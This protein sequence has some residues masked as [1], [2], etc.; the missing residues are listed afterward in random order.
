MF[1]AVLNENG[2]TY[3]QVPD[4]I[5][6]SDSVLVAVRYCGICGSD[7]PRVFQHKVRKLP[8]I[9]GHEFSGIVVKIGS[10]VHNVSVGESVVGIP[11]I[12][13]F[14]CSVCSEG[15]YSSCGNYKFV[16]SRL[17]GGYAQYVS[18]PSKN[19]I[20][21]P[22]TLPLLD[23]ALVEP[24]TVSKHAFNFVNVVDKDV[25]VVGSGIIGLFT[26]QWAKIL[27]AKKVTLITHGNKSF[28]ISDTFADIIT[29]DSLVQSNTS[30]VVFDC[31][32][33]SESF[34]TDYYVS[35][36]GA[37]VVLI[38]TPTQQVNFS[39]SDWEL[40]NRKE[41]KIIG[42]WMSYSDPFPGSEWYESIRYLDSG[43]LKISKYMIHGVY[44]LS[45]VKKVFSDIQTKKPNGRVIFD[46]NK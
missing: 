5:L 34:R 38:G 14:N 10:N 23:A 4:P 43:N 41:L 1:A 24:S 28:E 21:I 33:N 27:G 12:P 35:K 42:S 46:I 30:D 18:L 36:P 17:N 20:V 7:Y 39:I 40:I 13:C 45:E 16:G 15:K 44:G 8:I 37:S 6:D 25:V 32:G 29:P 22:K 3:S 31:A 19:V 2:I 26:I 9:L 11:L